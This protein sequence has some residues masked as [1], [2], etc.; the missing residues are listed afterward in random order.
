MALLSIYENSTTQQIINRLAKLQ[1]DA[2]PLWGKM[3]VA[4]M[5]HHVN[6]TYDVA[7]GK[8]Q[9]KTSAIVKFML[10]IFAKKIVV[11]TEPYKRNSPTAKYLVMDATFDFAKE[12]DNLISN[13]KEAEA[14]GP[15]YFEGK[16]SNGFGNLTAQEWSNML[17]KHIDHH[18]CQ[19]GV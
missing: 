3:N 5:L 9:P 17:Y 8:Y 10:K 19:F 11:G 2:P 7:Y 13:V 6:L 14:K 4:Q 16:D 1:A 15:S 12:K 18:L